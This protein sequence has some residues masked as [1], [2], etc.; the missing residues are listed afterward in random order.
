MKIVVIGDIAASYAAMVGQDGRAEVSLVAD[1]SVEWA[2]ALAAANHGDQVVLTELPSGDDGRLDELLATAGDRLVLSR[3]LRFDRLFLAAKLAIRVGDVGILRTVHISWS[4]DRRIEESDPPDLVAL[5]TELA[6]VAVWLLDDEPSTV[7]ALT[8]AVDGP[9]LITVNLQTHSGLLALLEATVTSTALPPCRDVSLLASD[10]AIYH[11]TLHDD[12]LWTATGAEVLTYRD[13]ALV[14]EVAAITRDAPDR[15][16]RLARGPAVGT[17]RALARALMR[18]VATG[19][20]ARV[21][22]DDG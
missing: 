5:A 6:D 13:D 3:P 18:S 21:G 11:R 2:S 19:Q 16:D 8:C 12:L 20:P 14:P 15:D 1:P 4:F 9:P 10:G 17:N 22:A 7:Y